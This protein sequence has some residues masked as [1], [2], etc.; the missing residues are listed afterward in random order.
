MEAMRKRLSLRIFFASKNVPFTSMLTGEKASAPVT[1]R[2]KEHYFQMIAGRMTFH[3][4]IRQG[5][6]AIRKSSIELA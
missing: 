6:F 2:S 3:P 1:K 5:K 4:P